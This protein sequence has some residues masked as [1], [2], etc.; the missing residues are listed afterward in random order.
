M[1][2]IPWQSELPSTGNLPL[3]RPPLHLETSITSSYHHIALSS[4]SQ[5]ALPPV[6]HIYQPTSRLTIEVGISCSGLAPSPWHVS[7]S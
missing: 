5:S 4:A 7:N 3:R 1:S 6:L 2:F